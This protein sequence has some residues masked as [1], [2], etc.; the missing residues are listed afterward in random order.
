[1]F[2]ATATAPQ[3]SGPQLWYALDSGTSLSRNGAPNIGQQGVANI[4]L[5]QD[6]AGQIYFGKMLG[7]PSMGTANGLANINLDFTPS[8]SIEHVRQQ[9][10]EKKR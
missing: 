2:D 9:T 10:I 7:T 6:D 8:H 3:C 4:F 5:L 1:M